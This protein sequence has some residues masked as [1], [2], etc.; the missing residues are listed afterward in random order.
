MR[1]NFR[2]LAAALGGSVV[3]LLVDTGDVVAVFDDQELNF[4]T[5][6]DILGTF[7]VGYRESLQGTPEERAAKL[8]PPT[9]DITIPEPASSG[10]LLAGGLA[11]LLAGRNRSRVSACPPPRNVAAKKLALMDSLQS[12]T[13][14][15][16]VGG[17][18]E[19]PKRV[20]SAW[21]SYLRNPC[22]PW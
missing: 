2:R 7:Y 13:L 4:T 8:R 14:W 12:A 1:V 20:D 10:L 16:G 3:A 11:L 5:D 6:T 15:G 22:D 21:P 17:G 19:P 18:A 9:F